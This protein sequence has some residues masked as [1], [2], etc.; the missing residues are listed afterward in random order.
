MNLIIHL[1]IKVAEV[2][3][4]QVSRQ[5]FNAPKKSYLIRDEMFVSGFR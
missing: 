2:K 5:N 4:V 3:K 1:G